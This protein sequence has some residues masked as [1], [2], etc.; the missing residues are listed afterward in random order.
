MPI[1]VFFVEMFLLL[2]YPSLAYVSAH[3]SMLRFH[4]FVVARIGSTLLQCTRD[5]RRRTSTVVLIY[6]DIYR[7]KGEFPSVPILLFFSLVSH[8]LQPCVDDE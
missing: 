1:L 4:F 2:L 3:K 5:V 6:R 7:C 8:S